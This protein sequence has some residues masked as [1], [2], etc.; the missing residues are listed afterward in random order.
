MLWILF[1]FGSAFFA[2]ITA[3]LAKIGI[4]HIN[5]TLATAV[6][7]VVVLAFSWLMVFVVGSQNTIGQI[8]GKTLLFLILSGLSTGASWLCYFKALQ[9]GDVNKVAP[10]D[11]SSTVLTILLALL[12]LGE[13]ISLPQILGVLGIG[14]GTLLMISK[15]EVDQEKPQSKSW[16]LFALL[17][18]IFASLTSI[19]GKMGVENVESNLGTAIRTIVVLAMA[20]AMVFVTGEQKDLGKIDRKS[21]FFLLLSGITTGLSW[22]CYYRA[23]QDGLASVVVP[24]DK[25]SILVTIVFSGLV[26]KEKLSRKAGMGLVLILAGTGAMLL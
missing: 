17:S 7:T 25:L 6:R 5:S 2:G 12:F 1:A 13:P 24:I 21:A 4:E 19:F 11:K 22:L 26:L 10:I 3:V 8:T 15:K 18:A 20:W 14:I 23:L 9:L 16:L